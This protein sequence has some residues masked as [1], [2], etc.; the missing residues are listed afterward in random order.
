VN[1]LP[2]EYFVTICKYGRECILGE[3][4]NGEM[5]LNS[6]GKI[7]REEWLRTPSV[8]LE[9]ELDEYIIMPNHLHGIIIIKEIPAKRMVNLVGTHG[10]ASLQRKRRSLGAIIA[11]FKSAATKRINEKRK[12]PR[13]PVWQPRFYDRIIR[14]GKELNNIRDYIHPVR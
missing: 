13:M 8:R 3:I 14:N 10:R 11:G 4:R 6:L 2:G 5:I 7:V 12:M 1:S 9:I